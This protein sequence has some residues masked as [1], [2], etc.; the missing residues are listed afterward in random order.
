MSFGAVGSLFSG[1]TSKKASKKAQKAQENA[2]QAALAQDQSQFDQTQ[3]NFKPF[4]DAGTG[5]LSGVQD[6][7]GLNGNDVQG[8][9]ISALQAS[10]AFTSLDSAGQDAILQNASAT[11]G[12][13][14][15]NVNSSLANFRSS[16]LSNVIQQQLGNL[17]GLVNNGL[18]A[19]NNLGALGAQNSAA[20]SNLLLGQ[21]NVQASGILGRQ[22][23][24][25]N[26]Q[27]G[28]YSALTGP[29]SA[30]GGGGW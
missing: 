17:G 15:G 23:I 7:L 13:R 3:A 26:T 19:T 1:I 14:G 28:I 22:Q 10:P 4:L 30:M 5:A 16:L 27:D 18:G 12:V 21:G 20:V 24:Q 11:G 29:F 2:Y 9:A 6:L 8:S 25:N